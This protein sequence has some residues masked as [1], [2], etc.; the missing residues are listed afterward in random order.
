MARKF[1]GIGNIATNGRCQ[2]LDIREMIKFGQ[3]KRGQKTS[4]AMITYIANCTSLRKFIHI[5]YEVAGKNGD[6]KEIDYRIPIIES[7]SNLGKG[8]IY[9][10]RCPES[11]NNAKVLYRVYGFDKFLHRNTYLEK[12]NLRI[13]YEVQ[14]CSKRDKA[15]IKYHACKRKFE[16]LKKELN[17]KHKNSH[18]RLMPTKDKRRLWEL[19]TR[20][21]KYN[22]IRLSIIQ[23]IISKYHKY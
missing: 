4:G 20:M 9:Y 15:N 10:L 12:Y 22:N 6:T 5:M 14:N 2:K 17:K 19:E 18:Y 8:T 16:A 3:I 1:K 7:P 13:Y 11:F 23:N 21:A